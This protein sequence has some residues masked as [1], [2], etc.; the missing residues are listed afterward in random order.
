[1]LTRQTSPRIARRAAFT[2]IEVL[3]VVTIV[4]ILASVGTIATLK[5]LDDAKED[6]A[7]Q[8][9]MSLEQAAKSL[10]V[11]KG[12]EQIQDISELIPYL[13]KGAAQ[14]VDPWGGQYQFKYIEGSSQGNYRIV[15]FTT[16]QKSGQQ[17]E[18]PKQ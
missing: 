9:M 18:W 2:L 13:E 12:G 17:V 4:V 8:T 11:K 7:I 14:L 16:N 15:F 3:V 1:M 5:Y 6:N 10:E